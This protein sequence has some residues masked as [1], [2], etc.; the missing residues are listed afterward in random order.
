MSTVHNSGDLKLE[1]AEEGGEDVE[2]KT[3][4]T[5]GGGPSAAGGDSASG[6]DS[7]G[8]G[9]TAGGGINTTGK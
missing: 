3:G 7:V 4:P 1:K 5:A 8:G 9:P 2:L 6:G